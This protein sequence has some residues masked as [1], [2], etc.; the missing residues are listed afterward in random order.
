[1]SKTDIEWC[2]RVWNPVTGC[3][4]VSAGCKNCYAERVAERLWAKQY[5]PVNGR[6]RRFTDVLTHADRLDAPLRWRKPQRVFVNSMSDLFHDDVP[7]EFIDRVFGV[8]AAARTQTFQVLTKRPERM[9]RWFERV[10]K[11]EAPDLFVQ[12]AAYEGG[13]ASAITHG[14]GGHLHRVKGTFL[15][16]PW[17]LPNVWLGVSVE[18]QRAAD[19]RIPL[20]LQT[21]AAVRFLSCEPLLSAIDLAHVVEANGWS[22]ADMEWDRK[23][24]D[25]M[26]C[27]GTGWIEPA[28]PQTRACRCRVAGYTGVGIDWV[29]A[30]GESGA[31]ARPCDVAWIR[32]L[33]EQCRAAGVAAFVKQLGA[34]PHW[35]GI[36]TPERP[37]F[38]SRARKQDVGGQ[39]FVKL[40]ST[41]GGDPAEW[42]EDLRVREFPR[43]AAEVR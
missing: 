5:P 28:G 17:P 34:A 22:V 11:I 35:N 31:G 29:I 32:S 42:P 19:E 12:R 4:K 6:P 2:D 18:G 40:L 36:V 21:P 33:V 38:P 14:A 43:A 25:C 27:G 8:M 26:T 13:C 16:F 39:F 9:L 23:A 30:G 10:A 24:W 3:T 1:V 37:A 15:S 7:D 20:L 41:K